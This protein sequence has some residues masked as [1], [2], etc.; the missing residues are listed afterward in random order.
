VARRLSSQPDAYCRHY[1][2]FAAVRVLALQPLNLVAAVISLGCRH[3][4]N[5]DSGEAA[6]V[7]PFVALRVVIW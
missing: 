3:S 1:L 7:W 6:S 2:V 4:V 5:I